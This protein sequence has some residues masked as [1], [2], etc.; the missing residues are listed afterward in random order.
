MKNQII[1]IVAISSL[2]FTQCNKTTNK[3]RITSQTYRG[4]DGTRAKVTFTDNSD[5]SYITIESNN[6][7]VEILK[8]SPD[9]YENE[10][11]KALV[12]G[13]SVIV[14]QGKNVIQLVK[15]K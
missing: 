3:E 14:T 12:K 7:K 6:K 2:L 8:K 15:D 13:D 1:I 4:T 11:M 10:S 9:L 5:R